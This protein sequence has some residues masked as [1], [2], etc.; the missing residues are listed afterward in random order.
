MFNKYYKNNNSS[1]GNKYLIQ[2][3]GFITIKKAKK[4]NKKIQYKY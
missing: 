4:N 3:Y 2:I 1:Q